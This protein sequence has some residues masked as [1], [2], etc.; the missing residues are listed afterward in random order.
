VVRVLLVDDIPDIL[1]VLE[2]MFSFQPNVEVVGT[3]RNNDE[4]LAVLKHKAVDIITIDIYMGNDNGFD[5]CRAVHR[6]KPQVF[7]TMCSS[8]GSPSNRQMAMTLG[9]HYF[10][11]K[12]IRLEDVQSLVG[13]YQNLMAEDQEIDAKTRSAY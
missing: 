2:L 5:L 1:E 4:A 12:P 7:I 10:L 3:V 11:E 9:A 8:E 6:I 13:T